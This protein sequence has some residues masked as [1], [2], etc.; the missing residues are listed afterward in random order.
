MCLNLFPR[1][2]CGAQ[3]LPGEEFQL[4]PDMGQ[5]RLAGVAIAEEDL[6]PHGIGE[7]HT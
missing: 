1:P 7:F 4:I 3:F 6:G 5:A 2:P